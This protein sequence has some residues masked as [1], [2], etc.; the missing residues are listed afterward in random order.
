M[1]HSQMSATRREVVAKN[2]VVAGGHELEA[3]AGVRV[4]QMGGNAIDAL[5]AAAFVGFV[6]EPESCGVGGYG[7]L[8]IYNAA[9]QEFVT[10]DHYVRA[11]LASRP[12]MFELDIETPWHYYGHPQTKGQQAEQGYLSP[13]VPG[14]VAGLC[15]AHEMFGKLPLAD[16]LQPAIEIAEAGLPVSWRLS[17]TI[18]N[19][20]GVIQKHPHL[21]QFLMP[22]GH[23][24]SYH[25]RWSAGT[26]LDTRD[27]AKTLRLIAQ[28]GPAGFYEGEIAA[29]IERE[30]VSNGGI[31]SAADLAAYQP[32]IMRERPS[33]YRDTEYITAYDQ[34]AYEILNILDTFDLASYGPDS[35]EFRHLV[36]EALGHGF[37]DNKVHYGD[38]DYTNSP[39][40][41][42]TSR[43]FAAARA[44][45]IGLSHAAPRPITAADPWPYETEALV[46]EMI[47]NMPT[48][49][50]HKGT[51][52]MVT[53]DR[54]GNMCA[55]ITS[56]SS[57]FGCRV[58]VPGTGI[59]LNNSM[60]NYD[61]RPEHPNHI[62]PGK[63]PIFAAPSL[64]ATRNKEAIFASGGS[65]GYRIMT[66]V[67]HAFMHAVDFG[68][69][70]QAAI[71]APRVH[72]QGQETAVDARIPIEVQQQLTAIGHKL[73]VVIDDPGANHFG[74]VV[75][76]WRDLETGL[77]HA[78]SGQAWVSAAAGY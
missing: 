4:M 68:M 52:T 55:L 17:L 76:L 3:E 25:S 54:D 22:N 34:V 60:Q 61:P 70:I 41:G 31:L 11:P 2:G 6:V 27:L 10:I 23:T 21:A 51:S 7:R 58:L 19:N 8:S 33:S 77:L 9:Q 44:A 49:G 62:Q 16:V 26:T 24:P 42:L 29:A 65:G 18:G 20:S 30:V 67:L 12:D 72:C 37:M 56:I 57:S 43:D 69:G 38:P 71:D 48:I 36:A 66:G 45:Q 50:Q 32:K 63:M 39:V 73:D 78:G 64:V 74:R 28:K 5:V 40:N 1:I 14:A 15:A 35:L 75:G 13:A 46:P 59:I 53:A 47:S